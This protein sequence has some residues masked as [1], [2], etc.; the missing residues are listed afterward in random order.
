M[1]RLLLDADVPPEV[2]RILARIGFPL[3]SARR[4]EDI[5]DEDDI[6]VVRWARKHRMIVLCF[7]QHDDHRTRLAWNPEIGLRGGRVLQVSEGPEQEPEQA[8]GKVLMLRPRWSPILRAGHGV[9]RLTRGDLT[10]MDQEKLLASIP[11]R[12]SEIDWDIYFRAMGRTR[13]A[14]GG[15][16][17]R[18]GRPRF[19]RQTGKRL[20]P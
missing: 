20:T 10:F 7:D 18:G 19:P 3:E 14:G 6:A 1:E 4:R 2:E 12:R 15:R 11:E 9:V 13:R 16:P 17:G 8:A 5:D